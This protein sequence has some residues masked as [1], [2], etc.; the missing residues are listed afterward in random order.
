MGTDGTPWLAS[1][2]SKGSGWRLLWQLAEGE[3]STVGGAVIG[4]PADPLP[5]VDLDNE[6]VVRYPHRQVTLIMP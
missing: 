3:S 4:G 5:D 1:V 2:G 6:I